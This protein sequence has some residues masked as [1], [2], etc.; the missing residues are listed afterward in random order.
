VFWPSAENLATNSMHDW[1]TDACEEAITEHQRANGNPRVIAV[2]TPNYMESA[3]R[4]S[5]KHPIS[6]LVCEDNI[7]VGRKKGF[8]HNA[9]VI[10]WSR[11]SFSKYGVTHLGGVSIIRPV[12]MQEGMIELHFGSPGEAEYLGS[13]AANS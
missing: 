3:R 5:W 8:G 11:Y 4:G 2:M 1:V 6:M 9:E 7:V 13:Y 12:H 10:N